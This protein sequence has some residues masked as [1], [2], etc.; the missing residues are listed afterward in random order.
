MQIDYG[1]RWRRGHAAIWASCALALTCVALPLQARGLE[2]KNLCV[3]ASG[4]GPER[5]CEWLEYDQADNCVW[6][7]GELKGAVIGGAEQLKER[8]AALQSLAE[9]AERSCSAMYAAAR[10]RDDY[11]DACVG[12]MRAID[13]ARFLHRADEIRRLEQ[14][15]ENIRGVYNSQFRGF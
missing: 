3:A 6:L 12:L 7:K 14:R 15:L 9:M 8:T 13:V 1:R 4:R 2:R 11:D 5:G 10:P